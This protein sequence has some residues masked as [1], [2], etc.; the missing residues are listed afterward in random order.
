MSYHFKRLLGYGM[1]PGNFARPLPSVD[2]GEGGGVDPTTPPTTDP[3]PP[4]DV[5]GLKT[6]LDAERK[7]AKDADRTLK[8]LQESVKGMDPEKYKQFEAL[9]QQAEEWNQKQITIRNEVETE[10]SGK[11]KVEIDRTKEFEG[12]YLNL[13]KRTEAE[14]AF[15]AAKG[16]SGAGDAGITYFDSLLAVID[17]SLRL[18]DKGQVEV[19]DANGARLFSKT[20]ASKPMTPK[21]YFEGLRSDPVLGHCFE[22]QG[23]AA[24]GGMPPGSGNG[25]GFGNNREDWSKMPRSERL[26]FARQQ[27]AG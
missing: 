26:T 25:N 19:I 5:S 24:G 23:H 21:E 11:L 1:F 10:W 22:R 9:Q 8:A 13:V 7:R 3:T 15:Q 12:K 20:D 17:K 14:K 4:E 27:A 6:A 2:G 18:N 16:R